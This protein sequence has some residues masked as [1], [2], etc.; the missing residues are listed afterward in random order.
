M[1]QITP[2]N[3]VTCFLSCF[4]KQG[5]HY[6]WELCQKNELKLSW[7]LLVNFSFLIPISELV[8]GKEDG[9]SQTNQFSDAKKGQVHPMPSI[10]NVEG[11]VL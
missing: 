2:S 8:M 11:I 6:R 5:E 1:W 10:I 3:G 4:H 9:L 7:N